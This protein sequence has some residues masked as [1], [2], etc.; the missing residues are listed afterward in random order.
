MKSKPSHLSKC[1]NKF[2]GLVQF[3]LQKMKLEAGVR[4]FEITD[5]SVRAIFQRI[6]QI[7]WL[8]LKRSDFFKGMYFLAKLPELEAGFRL[9]L[10]ELNENFIFWLNFIANFALWIYNWRVYRRIPG[11][12]FM[13]WC[14]IYPHLF[15]PPITNLW[16]YERG[17]ELTDDDV[18]SSSW[19]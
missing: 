8:Q 13:S 11:S 4:W 6:K 2:S 16:L 17:G 14:A 5:M 12:N 19:S 10:T 3:W 15:F 9:C 1:I 18:S 7:F